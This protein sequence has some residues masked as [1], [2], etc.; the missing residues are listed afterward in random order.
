MIHW[1]TQ[2][3]W[4][5]LNRVRKKWRTDD[6][7]LMAAAMAYYVALA[8]FPLMLLVVSGLGLVLR[9]SGSD[10]GAKEE[11]L[12]M[13]AD[14]WASETL[15][16][17]VDDVLAD[18]ETSAMFG[19]PIGVI[20]LLLAS[21]A[22]FVHLERGLARIWNVERPR[23]K[24]PV[25]AVKH[26]L[27][28]RLKAFLL[29]FGLGAMITATFLGGMVLSTASTLTEQMLGVDSRFWDVLQLLVTLLLNWL[30]FASIYKTLS[31]VPVRWIEAG[32][33]GLVAAV[34]WEIGRQVLAALV[35]GE[36][37]S[38]YGVVGAFLWVMLWI[39]YASTVLFLGAEYV[40]AIQSET[41]DL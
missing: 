31:A 38:A 11:L 14:K 3:F 18:V 21:I 1:L 36:R 39:Y 12:R 24:G 2:R 30:L 17:Q 34:V 37:Y 22:I 19:G 25:A 26:V 13:I 15:A 28:H 27:L 40:E 29:L 20:L 4:P 5:R 33:G 10:D 16:Q 6:G 32:R 7:N 9:Y 41:K 23:P 8:F 35:I